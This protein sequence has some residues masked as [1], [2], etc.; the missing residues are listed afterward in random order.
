MSFNVLS[1][2][3]T[4]LGRRGLIWGFGL[5]SARPDVC[6]GASDACRE[7][8]YAAAMERLRP[9]VL[10]RYERNLQLSRLPDFEAVVVALIVVNTIAVVRIHVGGDFYS[11]AY[12]RKWLRIAR[13]LPEVCFYTYTRSWRDRR[14]RPV[15]EQL[16]GLPNVRVWYSCDRDTGVPDR[17]PKRVRLAW[18]MTAQDDLPPPRADL[19][20]RVRRLR[21]RQA[22]RIGLTLVCPVENGATGHRTDCNRCGVCWR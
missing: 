3:N 9:A 8:C 6:V 15:I 17:V 22:K 2:G 11:A 5:P 4:K 18:L 12:A 19:V 20:F 14:I 1:P 10:A 13:R 21:G 16:A 7:H